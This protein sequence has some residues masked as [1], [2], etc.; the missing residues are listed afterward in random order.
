[1]KKI[2]NYDE[3]SSHTSLI[4]CSIVGHPKSGKASLLNYITKSFNHISRLNKINIIYRNA[5]LNNIS[6]SFVTCLTSL[7]TSLGQISVLQI[8]QI[9]IFVI[10]INF[11]EYIQYILETLMCIECCKMYFCLICITH[12]ELYDSQFIQTNLNK[13]KQIINLTCNFKFLII[14]PIFGHNMNHFKNII[15]YYSKQYWIDSPIIINNKPYFTIIRSYDFTSNNN[16][17]NITGGIVGGYIKNGFLKK[18]SNI[19][20][21]PGLIS[22]DNKKIFS[23]KSKITNIQV[24]K[25]PINYCL[26]KGINGIE[27]S[28]DPYFTSENKL[29]GHILGNLHSLPPVYTKIGFKFNGLKKIFLNTPTQKEVIMK[30]LAINESIILCINSIFINGIIT[31]CFSN[32]SFII[33]LTTPKCIDLHNTTI[34]FRKVNFI[35]MVSGFA[36]NLYGN[37]ILNKEIPYNIPNL[38]TN[39]KDSI[40]I[41]YSKKN[42]LSLE[43]N[44][45]FFIKK[46]IDPLEIISTQSNQKIKLSYKFNYFLNIPQYSKFKFKQNQLET[47]LKLLNI[48]YIKTKYLEINITYDEYIHNYS[49]KI[50]NIFKCHKCMSFT[51]MFYKKSSIMVQLCS[52]CGYYQIH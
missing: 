16:N 24:D 33:T 8:S 5:L 42:I 13:L 12:T 36:N 30:S 3:I 26:P 34:V 41:V 17:N 45:I 37:P 32:N 50:K 48:L 19:Y 14:N 29:R 20:I 25:S 1:M 23:I 52:H 49:K 47:A 38:T 43:E 9:C 46:N 21:K 6:H 18:N 28:I 2:I 22:K 31:K 11:K 44:N 27:L 4:S 51:F 10:S 35:W 39:D 7:H 15:N 40:L